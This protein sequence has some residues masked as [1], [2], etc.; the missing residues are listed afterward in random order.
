MKYYKATWKAYGYKTSHRYVYTA[1]AGKNIIKQVCIT[2]NGE[3]IEFGYSTIESFYDMPE[4]HVE[5][6]TREEFFIHII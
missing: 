2:D 5:E 1:Q 6:I 3:K 4:W